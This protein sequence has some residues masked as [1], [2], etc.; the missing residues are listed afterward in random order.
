MV[1]AVADQKEATLLKWIGAVVTLYQKAGFKI[2]T[3]LMDGEFMPLCGGLAE[4]GITLNETSRDEYVGHIEQYIHMVKEHM[5]AI[6]NTLPFQKIPA[7]P[8]IEMTKTAVF[9]LNTV[10]MMGGA[11][12]DLSPRTILMGQQMDYKCHCRFQFGEYVQTHEEH[13]NSMNPRTVGAL[14]LRPVGN[15]KGAF[16]F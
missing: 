7:W 12:Q 8:V 2:T 15:A 5:Q 6:Y 13:N 14:A 16:I 11:S 3:V 1:E 10:P 9:W 4:L